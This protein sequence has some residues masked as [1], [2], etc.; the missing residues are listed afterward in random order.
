MRGA[1]SAA[2]DVCR[3]APEPRGV[4]RSHFY[5]TVA[6]LRESFGRSAKKGAASAPQPLVSLFHA[7]ALRVGAKSSLPFAFICTPSRGIPASASANQDGFD[8]T[9]IYMYIYIY[10]YIFIY[11]YRERERERERERKREGE[12]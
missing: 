6:H 1:F 12:R 8:A 4:I 3:S 7:P 11:I 10:I 9:L 2:S 5:R